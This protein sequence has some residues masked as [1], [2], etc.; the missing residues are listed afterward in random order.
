M[1]II[2]AVEFLGQKADRKKELLT[3]S[4]ALM[5]VESIMLSEVSQ[6]EKDKY[7]MISFICGI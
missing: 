4:T 5:D 6:A 2:P 7:H 1:G 3:F